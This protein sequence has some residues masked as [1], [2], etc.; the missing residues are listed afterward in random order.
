MFLSMGH[1]AGMDKYFKLKN[2]SNND[3]CSS[4]VYHW[5]DIL[6]NIP[7]KQMMSDNCPI[8]L[9]IQ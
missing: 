8:F 7:K 3:V 4:N 6:Q 2:K 5:Y 1:M 9:L